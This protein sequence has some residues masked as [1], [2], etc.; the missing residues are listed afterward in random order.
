MPHSAAQAPA[1]GA[2]DWLGEEAAPA[3]TPVRIPASERV[4]EWLLEV[5]PYLRVSEN[6]DG[7]PG[8]TLDE[9]LSLGDHGFT[10]VHL[11]ID[12]LRQEARRRSQNRS[13]AAPLGVPWRE[14]LRLPGAAQFAD[15]AV[16]GGAL[17]GKTPLCLLANQCM[18]GPA[19][20]AVVGEIFTWLLSQ[21][22]SPD[23]PPCR[24]KSPLMLAAESGNADMVE[25]LLAARAS[26][27]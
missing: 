9:I 3:A 6:Q 16:A 19:Y 12:A 22:A 24:E 17:Q 10:I 8:L 20:P 11:V 18:P 27:E 4:A 7:V 21:R 13:M 25:L 5:R 23:L 2:L 26:M 15:A 14:V 1:R